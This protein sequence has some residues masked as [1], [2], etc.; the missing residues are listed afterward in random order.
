MTHIGG[1]GPFCLGFPSVFVRDLKFQ[2]GFPVA[3]G[4]VMPI[5]QFQNRHIV[6]ALAALL[7][8]TASNLARTK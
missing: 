8:E 7:I 5:A 6:V 4:E 1:I 3:I 2:A